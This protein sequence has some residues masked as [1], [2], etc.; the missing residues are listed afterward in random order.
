MANNSSSVTVQPSQQSPMQSAQVSVTDS[1]T[2]SIAHRRISYLSYHISMQALGGRDHHVW[3]NEHLLGIN[4]AGPYPALNYV[5]ALPPTRYTSRMG[6]D[7]PPHLVIV[8]I[9]LQSLYPFV[10][11]GFAEGLCRTRERKSASN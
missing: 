6:Y 4:P 2:I 7:D 5:S 10:D 11:G 3:S 9:R 1:C 8:S